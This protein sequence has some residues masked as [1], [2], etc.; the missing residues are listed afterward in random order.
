VA[1]RTCTDL[2]AT[3]SILSSTVSSVSDIFISYVFGLSDPIS[4]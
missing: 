2:L 1:V 4:E 3:T